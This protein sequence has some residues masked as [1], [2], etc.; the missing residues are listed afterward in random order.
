MK[1]KVLAV[2]LA[3]AL[4]ISMVSV[5]GLLGL[6]VS[7]DK[8]LGT[9]V[10]DL[11]QLPGDNLIAGRTPVMVN[12]TQAP[13]VVLGNGKWEQA[14]DGLVQGINQ[15]AKYKLTE[16]AY[17][18]WNSTKY[19]NI[20]VPAD[21]LTANY[22]AYGLESADLGKTWYFACDQWYILTDV[23]DT[24]VACYTSAPKDA[25]LVYDL[26]AEGVTVEDI[27]L[28][29]SAEV[30][31]V[32][33]FSGNATIA[34]DNGWVYGSGAD[35]TTTKSQLDAG[36]LPR[37]VASSANNTFYKV[38]VYVGDVN[39]ATLPSASNL[40]LSY[41]NT[42]YKAEMSLATLFEV[43]T[44]KTGRYVCI[45][46]QGSAYS[47]QVR[48]SELGV[49]GQ[50]PVG[51]PIITPV[52]VIPT[53][54]NLLEGKTPVSAKAGATFP[55]SGK[56]LLTDGAFATYTQ[57]ATPEHVGRW[58]GPASDAKKHYWDLG[59]VYNLNKFLVGSEGGHEQYIKDVKIYVS[60][61]K[62]TLFEA[63]NLA[64]EVAGLTKQN[65]VLSKS[66]ST[67]K[68]Q[69]VGFEFP[70]NFDGHPFWSNLRLGELGVYGTA[71]SAA[72]PYVTG[73][74]LLALNGASDAAALPT[75]TNLLNKTNRL[76]SSSSIGGT[77]DVLFDGLYQGINKNVNFLKY[78][79]ASGTTDYNGWAADGNY[80]KTD[81]DASRVML[82][83]K[84]A[85]TATELGYAQQGFNLGS[86]T[87][88][89]SVVIGS[90]AEAPNS[91]KTQS[92]FAEGSTF[93]GVIT[94]YSTS[95]RILMADVYVANDEATLYDDANKKVTIDY[96]E[97]NIAGS[98]ANASLTGIY[99][100]NEAAV[101]QYIG[102]RFYV[103]GSGGAT[104][105]TWGGN[106][107]NWGWYD[108]VR[109]S[110]LGAY[111]VPAVDTI[112]VT[113]VT[114]VPADNLLAGVTP[115]TGHEGQDQFQGNPNNPEAL[116]DGV[117]D[118]NEGGTHTSR[119]M[120]YDDKTVKQIW[121]LGD[122]YHLDKFLIGSEDDAS[123][124]IKKVKIYVADDKAKL[125]TT[126][127]LVLD[128]TDITGQNNV[129]SKT[130]TTFTGRYVGFDFT[131]AGNAIYGTARFGELGVYGT[132]AA[133]SGALHIDAVTT[134]PADNRLV[135]KT[136][137]TTKAGSTFTSV[138]GYNVALL[139]DGAFATYTAGATP[140]HVGRWI[141]Y[142]DTTAKHYW[143]L[144]GTYE[145]DKF[146]VGSEGGPQ[147]FIKDVK[148]YVGDSVATLFEEANLAI[149]AVGITGQNNV[150]YRDGLTFTGR[151]VG[152]WFTENMAGDPYWGQLRLGELGAYGTPAVSTSAPLVPGVNQLTAANADRI[153]EDNRLTEAT[154]IKG[155][156]SDVAVAVDGKVPGVNIDAAACQPPKASFNTN[157]ADPATTYDGITVPM[158]GGFASLTYQLDASTSI[159]SLLVAG[160]IADDVVYTLGEKKY[161][162]RHVRYYEIYISENL[163][164]LFTDEKRVVAYD[165]YTTP[166]LAQIHVLETPVRGSYVGFKLTG[167]VY[168]QSRIGEL[169]VY[170][171][172]DQV[173][174]LPFTGFDNQLEMDGLVNNQPN[175]IKGESVTGKP[176]DYL[177]QVGTAGF[178]AASDEAWL[179]DGFVHWGTGTDAPANDAEAKKVMYSN[180]AGKNNSLVW[181]M[182]GNVNFT[183]VMV[184]SVA[185]EGKNARSQ[186]VSVYVG[187]DDDTLFSPANLLGVAKLKGSNVGAYIDLTALNAEGRYIGISI[188]GDA[189]YGAV[190]LA[191]VG[192][193][194]TYKSG[195]SAYP[196]NL[197][198]NKLPVLQV[199][200]DARGLG[201]RTSVDVNGHAGTENT[202]ALVGEKKIWKDEGIAYLT[203]GSVSTRSAQFLSESNM[204]EPSTNKLQYD[205]PW[206]VLVYALGGHSRVDTITLSSSAESDYHIAGVQY[207]AS[208][209]YDDLFKN[210]SLLY[211]SGGEYYIVD[212]ERS[213]SELRRYLPDSSTDC[214]DKQHQEYTLTAAQNAKLYRYVAVVITRPF[215]RYQRS[216]PTT[217]LLGYSQARVSE[218]SVNGEVMIP[219]APLAT[220]YTQQTSV[221]EVTMEIAP[222]NFDDRDFF[223]NV[224][225]GFKVTE[226][227]L[228]DSVN[229]NIS[230]N[231]LSVDKDILFSIQM[232]DKEGQP[233]SEAMLN[234]RQVE[235]TFPSTASYVQTM[236]VLEDGQLRRLYNSFT[237]INNDR[238]IKAGALNYPVYLEGMPN[239]RELATLNSAKV[240]LVYMKANDIKTI[241]QLSGLAINESLAEFSGSGGVAGVSDTTAKTP[242][243]M[244]VIALS[245]VA[246]A[247]AV[248]TVIVLLGRKAKRDDQ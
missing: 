232:V 179:S 6:T 239:N 94:N 237:D 81:V 14:T 102:F 118:K 70:G 189:A 228:P 93:D 212:E 160:S 218:F 190:R 131:D 105:T 129:I 68:G 183:G 204:D 236:A 151:Y 117:F 48:I 95:T 50:M 203:D 35:K 134:A 173:T 164:D 227:K 25:Q 119:F 213:T 113:P 106:T 186:S 60:E 149:D 21:W 176:K 112:K 211:T 163:S 243:A 16:A 120:G 230:D 215:S 31:S 10:T 43:D 188:P 241:Y 205:T 109:I 167:G 87:A 221:G 217:E 206:V 55:A 229:R 7:A 178:N 202:G 224:L 28:A 100:L 234:G 200:V 126:D 32:N 235:Y 39:D 133:T 38:N 207:Y 114:D 8:N 110:E 155:N 71:S 156:G 219:E 195:P 11:A 77:V 111:G 121:D 67:F 12:S 86:K 66:G 147:Q 191:E 3:M 92:M 72:S 231:W 37:T 88:I 44:V 78:T 175:L 59:A 222:V 107:K 192:V 73:A 34:A 64:I 158:T 90:N 152:F 244:P 116:T 85:A 84:Q 138:S 69:Y 24:R 185:S 20:L 196:V 56:E 245:A 182:L 154:L 80:I 159:E 135:G 91:Q 240:S 89:T 108:Q 161:D 181:D 101:G 123:Y 98:T 139:T 220:T 76:S 145:L 148:I 96:L 169:G 197:V 19:K 157:S 26:G 99:E 130:G 225:G 153:P 18:E 52:T 42:D 170:G 132:A 226:S 209:T 144:G 238:K 208:E 22:E 128:V 166:Q 1:R 168:T 23:T 122:T 174:E 140:D 74:N 82:H 30:N 58:M 193:Y 180:P 124:Y 49:Y 57:G 115:A 125:F 54:T 15:P 142:P 51:L 27:F 201:N 141:G 104:A 137:I 103:A 79:G 45:D 127:A 53:E 216:S 242:V 150:L 143:D 146:L 13:N 246:M 223:E 75:D 33:T 63:D 83:M 17:F 136:P 184:S 62:D 2:T 194:G 187:N 214:N 97:G 46:V 210:E 61:D 36:I 29:I 165:N 171:V 47:S 247:A 65:N 5:S 248:V 177:P 172:A 198:L 233:L 199:Q 41:D 40:V 9:A 4:L 162:N